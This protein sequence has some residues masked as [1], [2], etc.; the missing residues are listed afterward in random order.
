MKMNLINL[1]LF[2]ATG[3][4]SYYRS[5]QWK[6][7]VET[8]LP[9]IEISQPSIP[10]KPNQQAAE[11]NSPAQPFKQSRFLSAKNVVTTRGSVQLNNV[12]LL[13]QD[14]TPIQSTVGI[15]V[16]KVSNI[17]VK[18]LAIGV[19]TIW[20]LPILISQSTINGRLWSNACTLISL[21]IATSYY[22][23]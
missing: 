23:N 16:P 17:E 6:E 18:P 19:L 5:D 1:S 7:Y 8:E 22:M 21:L 4:Y 15:P 20:N 9:E 14:K 10:H 13:P 3:D 2:Q 12:E 11:L